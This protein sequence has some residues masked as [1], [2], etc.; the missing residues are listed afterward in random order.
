M[1][2]N[3]PL[4]LQL[5]FWYFAVLRTLPAPKQ[6]VEIFGAAFLN[7]RGLFVPSPIFEPGFGWVARTNGPEEGSPMT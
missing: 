6:S 7:N 1:L 5:F 4:L 3:I 2:R